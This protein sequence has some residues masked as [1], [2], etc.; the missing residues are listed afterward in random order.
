MTDDSIETVDVK[1]RVIELD[2]VLQLVRDARYEKP[3]GYT[4]EVWNAALEYIE[5]GLKRDSNH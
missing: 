3:A 5:E 2:E 1:P 4:E